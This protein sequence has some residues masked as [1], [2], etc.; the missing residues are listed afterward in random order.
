MK[1]NASPDWKRNITVFL[2]SQIISLLGSSL[3]Q[4]AIMW[5]ITLETRSGAMMT[6]Y[7][8]CGFVPTFMLSPFGGVWADRYDRKKLIMIADGVIALATLGIALVFLSGFK[9]MWLLFAVAAVRATGSAAHG[10]A[11]GA[12]LPQMVPEDKLLRINGING[13]VQ[14]M[15]MLVSPILS[16]ALLSFASIE[17]IFF[18]DVVTAAI[19]IG[20]LAIFLRIPA[21]AKAMAPQTTGYFQ[22]MKMGFR[23]IREH[24]YLASFF[25]YLGVFVFLVTPAAFLTP[26]QTTRT[27]GP[28]VWRLTSLE[29]LFSG[30]MMAG[31]ALLATWGGF[32]NRMRTMVVSNLI[33]AGCTIALGLAPPFWLYLAIMG[34]FGISMPMY[35]T[36]SMVMIQEHVEGDYMGRVFSILTMLMTSAMPLG[37]L[38]FGPLADAIRIEWILV[39]SGAVMLFHGLRALGSRRLMEAGEPVAPVAAGA[40]PAK[41]PEAE[42]AGT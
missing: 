24:R 30:G 22:D 33:M 9:P 21:H 17:A 26:L 7:I 18:I 3:V 14:S 23:Y 41:V 13:S 40:S 37:M 32:R 31:G 19:A 4:Y 34:I 20:T 42:A 28:E 15:I 29:I 1:P 39:A 11:V 12:I 8:I 38:I 6:A 10:P 25:I 16:G 35:N 2:G 36:P 27:F 5:Y